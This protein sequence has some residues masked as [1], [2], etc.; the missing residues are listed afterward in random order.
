MNAMV[1]AEVCRAYEEG[2]PERLAAHL[3]KLDSYLPGEHLLTDTRGRDLVSGADRCDLLKPSRP[4]SGPPRLPDGRLVLIGGCHDH[5]TRYRFISIVRP[6]FDPPNI[7]P[8]YGAIVIVIALLG[9]VLAVHLAAP[10]RRLRR[11]VDRFG[12]GDLSARVGSARRDEIGELSR[13][14]DEMAGRIE[15]LL[16]AERRLLQDV[17]H[18]LR[19][20]LTRLDVAA[21]L[22]LT[23]E[24][25]G[26]LLVRI[27]RDIGRLSVLVDELLQLTRAGGDPSALGREDVS[28]DELLRVLID[29]CALEAAARGCHLQHR[30]GVPSSI[31]GERE[32]LHR[33]I[34][35]VVRNAIRHAPRG[36]AV[37]VDLQQRG[38]G[39]AVIVRDYGPGVPE[40]LLGAIFEPFFR[41]EGHR[42]RAS[43]GT[44]LG[45]VIARRAV[46]LHRGTI[47]ARNAGPGLIVEIELPQAEQDQDAAL[48]LQPLP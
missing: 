1:E 9:S 16:A 38:R 40:E 44:G 23:S 45:L 43:G 7:L 42:S 21:D 14:F 31:H 28:L 24:D 25:R 13:A 12:Q 19:S 15:T 32:L 27:K 18:E 4:G 5:G 34:E 8:Y 35:N 26:P 48:W 41:V 17:S 20:P 3:R 39:M 37:E 36:T 2:G 46:A 33:A 6:W 29:D 47:S 30:A 22:A 11:V 10:L